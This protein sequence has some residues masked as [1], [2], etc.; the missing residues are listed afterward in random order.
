[1]TS[2]SKRILTA[3]VAVPLILIIILCFPQMDHL[4]FLILLSAVC[5]L[6]SLEMVGILNHEGKKPAAVSLFCFLL[7]IAR[8]IENRYFPGTSL[9]LFSFIILSS[10]SLAIEVFSSSNDDFR[11]TI[12]INSRSILALVYPGLFSVFIEDICFMPE[13]SAYLI[14]FFVFVFGSDSFALF[15]GLAFGKNNKG[16]VKVSPNKSIAGFIGGIMVPSLLGLC[17]RLLFPGIFAFSYAEGFILGFAASAAAALGDLVE[18]AFKRSA[19]I[20]DSGV[21]IPG[22]GGVLD[23]IDSLLLAAPVFVFLAKVFLH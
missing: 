13:A 17:A 8:Y 19:A 23:S 5:F 20:K 6:A 9:T 3:L 16:F 14:L 11:K 21:L 12:D 15:F 2:M 22:R 10:I 4:A 1:M 18:S 7:P